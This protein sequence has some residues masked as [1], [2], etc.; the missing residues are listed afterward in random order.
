MRR[1]STLYVL[2][3]YKASAF[4]RWGF[5]SRR[6]VGEGHNNSPCNKAF[7]FCALSELSSLEGEVIW[8]SQRCS[9]GSGVL[10]PSA[11]AAPPVGWV[12]WGGLCLVTTVDHLW[13]G[14]VFSSA[15]PL[16]EENGLLS[17]FTSINISL[18]EQVF[19]D[20]TDLVTGTVPG[21]ICFNNEQIKSEL[22]D[23]SHIFITG[24]KW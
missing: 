5:S 16:P 9:P 6:Q 12:G 22:I 18:C 23:C 2:R 11:P 15:R 10:T 21:S 24:G 1:L 4:W 7:H 19:P 3:F 8:K 20:M 17:R 14:E 13:W